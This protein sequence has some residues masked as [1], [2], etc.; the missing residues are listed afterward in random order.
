MEI[1]FEGEDDRIRI[2]DWIVCRVSM[3]GR[4][5]PPRGN[6]VTW[7]FRSPFG[8]PIQN[9]TQKSHDRVPFNKKYKKSMLGFRQDDVVCACA[10]F[11]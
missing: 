3:R 8:V 5:R 1:R 10:E 11:V 2:G 9:L 7:W 4:S 6:S